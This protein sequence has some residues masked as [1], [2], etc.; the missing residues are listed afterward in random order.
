MSTPLET[1]EVRPVGLRQSLRTPVLVAGIVSALFGLVILIW[2]V[3]S[4][5]AMTIVVAIYAIVAGVLNL[6]SGIFTRGMKGTSR[7][8]II[9]LGVLLVI[10]GIVAFAN[11]GESTLML[12]VIVTTFVGIAWIVEG[13]FTLTTLGAV[14][15]IYPGATK[16]HK[17]WT[18]ISAVISIVAGIL[19]VLSPV[20]TALWLW[21]FLGVM[22]IIFGIFSIVRA[23][24]LE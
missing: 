23:A 3:K 8:A 12:A 4:A 9:I 7:A 21:I 17:A 24:S 15:E 5:L 20:F 10:A 16:G 19:V 6:A 11:L 18:I 14:D 1:P 2:P 13:V 22:G